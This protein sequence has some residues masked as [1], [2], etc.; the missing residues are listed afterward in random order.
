MPSPV[1]PAVRRRRGV[2]TRVLLLPSFSD[3]RAEHTTTY[4]HRQR[5]PTRRVRSLAHQP[6]FLA[7]QGGAPRS[8]APRP[9]A[10]A[11]KRS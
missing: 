11:V 2:V 10:A 7:W 6:Q 4:L 5:R 3:D 8:A 9:D 1:L